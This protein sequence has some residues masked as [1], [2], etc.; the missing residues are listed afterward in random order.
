[1]NKLRVLS[2]FIVALVFAFIP[3]LFAETQ[4]SKS[5]EENLPLHQ[6]LSVKLE[7]EAELSM[8]DHEAEVYSVEG[9]TEIYKKNSPGWVD[10]TTG[11]KVQEGDQIKTDK[12]GRTQVAYDRFLLNHLRI[13]P[14]SMVEFKSIEPTQISIS[15]GS[16]FNI[17]DALPKGA[18]YE[19][20]SPTAVASVRGTTFAVNYNPADF[21][22]NMSVGTGKVEVFPFLNT[23]PLDPKKTYVVIAEHTFGLKKKMDDPGHS[24]IG[25][26]RGMS[27][28]EIASFDAVIDESRS[29]LVEYSGG[30]RVFS[31]S[32]REWLTFRKN[33]EKV[34]LLN[35]MLQERAKD[36]LL[37]AT[38][39]ANETP[40]KSPS[41]AK[42]ENKT[43][44]PGV[45][46]SSSLVGSEQ[47]KKLQDSL[48]GAAEA[49]VGDS[50]EKK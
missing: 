23:Q 38:L 4:I 39:I 34:A 6:D 12:T 30:S 17:L 42:T 49:T 16:L 46:V 11:T 1:M 43:S 5:V 45:I 24:V 3:N 41:A 50:E 40:E 35:Q 19:V 28:D 22:E 32:L 15:D 27:E 9:K 48:I 25:E 20:V 47:D 26:T 31:K 29:D 2:A 44:A 8:I 10:L 18:P 14:N 7:S 13:E 37:T 36:R 21:Q 33:P